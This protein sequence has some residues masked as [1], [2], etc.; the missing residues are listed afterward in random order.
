[1]CYSHMDTKGSETVRFEKLKKT[2][3]MF[4]SS[5]CKKHRALPCP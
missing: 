5:A 2:S 4:G 1:M 3:E